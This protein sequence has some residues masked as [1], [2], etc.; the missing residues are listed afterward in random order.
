MSKITIHVKKEDYLET[1][2]NFL[3]TLDYVDITNVELS[4][5]DNFLI[6]LKASCQSRFGKLIKPKEVM[7][8]LSRNVLASSDGNS[9]NNLI[10]FA[11]NFLIFTFGHERSIPSNPENIL[12][13]LPDETKLLLRYIS[14]NNFIALSSFEHALKIK[15]TRKPDT[16]RVNTK[17]VVE[18]IES[19][20]RENGLS[21]NYIEP[22]RPTISKTE[23]VE[24]FENF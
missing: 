13:V 5:F 12:N 7:Y 6:V 4:N 24:L 9:K 23:L 20:I 3:S 14:V 8:N 21:S 2:H 17:D 22:N 1:L 18:F 11:R 10:S 19:K 16:W 15:V